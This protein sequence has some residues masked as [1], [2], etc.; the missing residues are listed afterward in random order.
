[1]T[2]IVIVNIDDL[3][4]QA[5]AGMYAAELVFLSIIIHTHNLTYNEIDALSDFKDHLF[6]FAIHSP[7]QLSIPVPYYSHEN[8][9]LF[10]L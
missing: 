9:F 10:Y 5:Y 8:F 3:L 6:A 1:M 4:T 7:K 2:A